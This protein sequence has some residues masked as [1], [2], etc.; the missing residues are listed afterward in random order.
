MIVLPLLFLQDEVDDAKKLK[1]SKN[2]SSA[3]DDES[4][5]ADENGAE[6]EEDLDDFSTQSRPLRVLAVEDDKLQQ[7]VIGRL[8]KEHTIVFVKTAEEALE[9]LHNSDGTSEF[10]SMVLMDKELPG[11]DGIKATETIA[12]LWP[13]L[14]TFLTTSAN[15]ADTVSG[16]FMAGARDYLPKPLTKAK[17]NQ[18]V[19]PYFP[20]SEF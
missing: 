5:G 11:M 3:H 16:S 6:E 12:Q 18:S 15:D 19:A 7:L 20:G 1:A 2:G 14:H 13:D 8:F 9:M 4:N 17:L 10:P